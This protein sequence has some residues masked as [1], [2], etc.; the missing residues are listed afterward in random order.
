MIVVIYSIISQIKRIIRQQQSIKAQEKSFYKLAEN[1]ATPV[2][3]IQK[4]ME[5]EQW[6]AIEILCS[7]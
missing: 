1:M 6:Q 3:G 5:L 4:K 7:V 2:T